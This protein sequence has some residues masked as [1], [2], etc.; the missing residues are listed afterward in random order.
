MIDLLDDPL[1]RTLLVFDVVLHGSIVRENMAGVGMRE[2]VTRGGVIV[3]TAPHVA[4]NYIDRTLF[5][6]IRS[7]TIE[8]NSLSM[9]IV[10]YEITYL[11]SMVT[12]RIGYFKCLQI[13]FP[14]KDFD[15][16]ELTLSREGLATTRCESSILGHVSLLYHAHPTPLHSALV[17]SR[18]REFRI[19]EPYTDTLF[20]LRRAKKFIERGWTLVEG[21]VGMKITDIPE[22]D[23]A[24][25]KER[26][27]NETVIET[28]CNH[29]FHGRCWTNLVDSKMTQNGLLPIQIQCPL[30][31]HSFIC[32]E[33]LVPK[34]VVVVDGKEDL[35]SRYDDY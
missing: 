26:L 1:V 20:K 6:R 7:L 15:V 30:C 10:R 29:C 11:E 22:D 2:F 34:R 13:D 27:N 12:L 8:T 33:A 19:M 24:V 31:R 32:T 5:D 18:K 21:G 4:K 3:A 17:R 23:C 9:L 16:N 35:E 28:R 14:K 25:C